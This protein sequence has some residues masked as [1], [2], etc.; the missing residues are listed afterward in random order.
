M[1]NSNLK[2]A[3]ILIIDDQQ[4]NIDLLEGFLEME[5]YVNFKS[6]TDPREVVNLYEIFKPNLIL[7][8]L[9]MPF[10][11]GFEV[12]KQLKSICP[13]NTFLPILVL[14][15]DVSNTSK[16]QALAGGASDFLTKPFDLIEVG[17]RIRN[18][19]FTNHLLQQLES[20]NQILE[21]KVK[22]RTVELVNTNIDL[23]KALDKA[24]ASDRLKTAFLQT[25]S[26]E[27]RTPLNGILGFASLLA[28][29]ELTTDEKLEFVD[30]MNL[31]SERLIKTI[32]DYVDM[33]MIVSDNLDF[34]SIPV[35]IVRL[36]K[37]EKK[38]F[39]NNCD[40]KNLQFNLL[41]PDDH[42]EL[43][44]HTDPELLQKV[45]THLIDNAIKFTFNGSINFGLSVNS[46]FVKF[47]VED[48]GIG[49][50]ENTQKRIFE[51]FMQGDFSDTRA[52][53]GSGLGLPITKGIVTILGGEISLK[54][55]PG[56]GSTF[57]ISI[58]NH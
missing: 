41:L 42:K 55:L 45:I 7:L 52:F 14:T 37:G 23:T 12:M 5:G 11:S 57:Y 15:A 54:S 31:S 35:D 4:S 49:I 10:L 32:T 16:Q 21:E 50:E 47:F 34:K 27:V 58:P 43:I 56:K 24:E 22:E 28:E 17:L 46:E 30:I 20:Q 13:V 39:Q 2:N 9:S 3:N 36:L 26:H 53:E 8:D 51:K 38:L 33:A 18:L 1:I 25:I 6:T 48:T 19:L 44:I 29:Q 40:A